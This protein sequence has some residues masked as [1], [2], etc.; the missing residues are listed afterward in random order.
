VAIEAGQQVAEDQRAGAFE[1]MLSSSLSVRDILR[2]QLLALKRQFLWPLVTVIALE[3]LFMWLLHRRLLPPFPVT[4]LAAIVVLLADI[5]AVSCVGMRRALTARS[6]NNATIST[7]FRV[8]L[9]PWAL[10]GVVVV[11][12]TFWYVLILGREWSPGWNFYLGLWFGFSLLTDLVLGLMAWRQLNTQFR[13]LALRRFHR[14]AAPMTPTAAVSREPRS[15]ASLRPPRIADRVSDSSPAV[16]ERS[17]RGPVP[18]LFGKPVLLAVSGILVVAFGLVLWKARASSSA[19]MVVSITRSNAPVRISSGGGGALIILPDGSLWRWG[20]PPSVQGASGATSPEQ[21]GTN[22]DWVQASGILNR[23]IGLRSDG[24]I[25]NSDLYN[26]R[27]HDAQTLMATG[28]VRADQQLRWVAVGAGSMGPIALRND[29]T[30]WTWTNSAMLQTGGGAARTQIGTN[31]DWISFGSAWSS[32]LALR[33]NGTLWAWG[34]V[35]VWG[36]PMSSPVNLAVPTQVCRE[37]NW[38]GFVMVGY[39]LVLTRSGEL[40]EPFHAAPDSELPAALNCR[41]VLSNAAPGRVAFAVSDRPML[42][43]LRADGSLWETTYQFGSG[44]ATPEEWRRVGKRSDWVSLFSGG[45]TAFGLTSD[46]ILWT[47]GYD[48][49]RLPKLGQNFAARIK[50]IQLGV[51]SMFGSTPRPMPTGTMPA[52]NKQPRPVLRLVTTNSP[53]ENRR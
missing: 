22:R 26:K 42:Y 12:G 38:A 34:N 14:S 13:Q 35:P 6:H 28:F 3:L 1:S 24:T 33:R 47:W 44:T 20:P 18:R 2:G 31:D 41:L 25:W 46:G 36:T 21:V 19:A 23:F 4:W 48:L 43:Q 8:L 9:T 45:G 15:S 10:L 49:G 32:S 29:G 30:L 39:P 51:K 52:Y 40:W 11:I 37:T 53:P 50:Q 27:G 7:V 16:P 17:G 5:T